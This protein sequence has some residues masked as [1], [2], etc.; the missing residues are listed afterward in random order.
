MNTVSVFGESDNYFAGM[1]TAGGELEDLEFIAEGAN[2]TTFQDGIISEEDIDLSQTYKLFIDAIPAFFE[3]EEITADSLK[4]FLDSSIYAYYMPIYREHETVFLTIAKGSELNPEVNL[5]DEEKEW[6]LERAGKWC[7]TEVSVPDDPQDSTLDY[8]RKMESYLE[9]KNIHNAEIYFV[10]WINPESLM[11]A[12]CFTGNK[13][14]TG[15][16]EIIIVAVDF[17]TYDES[18]NLT[19]KKR[20]SDEYF[21]VTEAEYTYEELWERNKGTNKN[22]ELSGGGGSASK[23]IPYGVY[24]AVA[25]GVI[26]IAGVI[27]FVRKKAQR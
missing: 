7:V 25:A 6:I 15:K 22:P 3:R 4:E 21:D 10:S 12:V 19:V 2:L 18:G 20:G 16:D 24:I 8:R 17:L 11:N 27:I 13:T 23:R 26:I 9:Y 1:D 5:N 14:E